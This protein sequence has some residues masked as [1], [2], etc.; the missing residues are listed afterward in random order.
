MDRLSI[1]QTLTIERLA[2]IGRCASRKAFEQDRLGAEADRKTGGV[3]DLGG[4]TALSARTRPASAQALDDLTGV[5]CS[6][7]GGWR[8]R[9]SYLQLLFPPPTPPPT[10]PH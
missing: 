9:Y 3:I 4:A 10:F 5:N 1:V 7:H 2:D 8:Q 6:S